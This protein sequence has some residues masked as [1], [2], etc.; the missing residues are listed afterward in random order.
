MAIKRAVEA[1]A[2]VVDVVVDEDGV[3]KRRFGREGGVV[4]R[5]RGGERR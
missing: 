3:R 1:V 4:E 5:G 2:V